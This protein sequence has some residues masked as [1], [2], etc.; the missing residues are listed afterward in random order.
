MTTF[1]AEP[2][3]AALDGGDCRLELTDGR[4]VPLAVRR[5]HGAARGGDHWLIDHCHGPSIDLGCGPGRLVHALVGK[6]LI[7]LGVD[8]S[9]SANRRCSDRGVP[10]VQ[11]DVFAPLPGE[12]RWE[13]AILADGNIGIG[14]DPAAL[15][16]RARRLLR[17]GGSV[18]VETEPFGQG[19]WR[20]L[21]RIDPDGPPGSWFRWATAGLETVPALA[22]SA[23]L[24]VRQRCRQDR[25]CFAELVRK[26]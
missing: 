23:G 3:D 25:R 20:G 7:A 9:P 24:V 13:H 26:E 22:R 12:G 4:T 17:P 14:G 8:A 10:A 5:W 15:L 2:F 19:L 21:A 11:S 16:R 18:L 6:G 1:A